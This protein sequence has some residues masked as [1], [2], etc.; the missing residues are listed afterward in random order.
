MNEDKKQTNSEQRTANSEQ[1]AL[2]PGSGASDAGRLA[3]SS[4]WQ[5]FAVK[6]F[7]LLNS[8]G[9]GHPESPLPLKTL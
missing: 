7:T 6:E 1:R 2:R 4:E 9:D 8:K 5:S 3:V